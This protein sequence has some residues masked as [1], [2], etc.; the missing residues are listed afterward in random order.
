MN[1]DKMVAGSKKIYHQSAKCFVNYLTHKSKSKSLN[2][3]MRIQGKPIKSLNSI[4]WLKF[5]QIS[6]YQKGIFHTR[7]FR[8][9]KFLGS[10]YHEHKEMKERLYT[11]CVYAAFNVKPIKCMWWNSS[12]FLANPT[13]ALTYH[14]W[15]DIA[16][17]L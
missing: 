15:F 11:D 8:E 12:F 9:T 16:L 2:N 17:V 1:G 7:N 10:T 13:H 3:S 5:F 4:G 14:T 6:F